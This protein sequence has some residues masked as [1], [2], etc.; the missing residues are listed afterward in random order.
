MK[1]PDSSFRGWSVARALAL[2]LGLSFWVASGSPAAEH[3]RVE[4]LT[5]RELS[6]AVDSIAADPI[7]PVDAKIH[8]L[9]Q[10]LE[11]RGPSRHAWYFRAADLLG[12]LYLNEGERES[13]I[14]YLEI[15]VEGIDDDADLCNTLGYIYAQE[16][17]QLDRAERLIR[18]A[19]K[20]VPPD[21]P[22]RVIGYYRDS[23]GWAFFR[24][25]KLD[26]AIVELEA[27]N[28]LAP[29]T[30]EIRGHMVDVY[31]GLD[32]RKDAEA[33]LVDDLVAAR[34]VGPELRA[35]LRRL[36]HT[37]PQGK[38]LPAE[39]EVERRVV[40]NEAAEIAEIE[41]EGGR[42]V[43][44]EAEDGFPLVATLYPAAKERAPVALLVPMLAGSRNDYHKLARELVKAGI[45]ALCLD[46]RGHGASVTDDLPNP[47]AFR[48]DL[49]RNL[50]GALLD[51]QAAIH[52]IQESGSGKAPPVAMVGASFGGFLAALASAEND[53]VTAIVLLSPGAADPYTE[54]IVH[55]RERPTLLVAGNDDAAAMAGA[56]QMIDQLDRSRSELVVL[57]DAGFGT[58]MLDRS[59]E[60][61][62]LIVR[63]LGGAFKGARG[64]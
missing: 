2:V 52:Y 29:S 23:L 59:P 53:A 43:R 50:H 48:E 1:P 27:A 4:K 35:R 25:G 24:Q 26:S 57:K 32:R 56:R 42:V 5:D 3:R 64:L 7:L 41:A 34:G 21:T 45:S 17:T 11:E 49:P 8:A 28:R 16:N 38:P 46:M 55:R 63:W 22:E 14:R 19:L 33:I 13:A 39:L 37:T 40:A 36:Y 60:L 12:R 6:A 51:L 62:P 30:A 58:E 15:A 31:E 10:L 47:V 9:E 61:V 44:L 18:K 54:A 20:L